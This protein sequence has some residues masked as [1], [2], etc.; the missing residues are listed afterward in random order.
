MLKLTL[1]SNYNLTNDEEETF[2]SSNEY[3]TR[4]DYNQYTFLKTYFNSFI[5]L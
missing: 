4:K 3:D 1:K 2:I 5:S